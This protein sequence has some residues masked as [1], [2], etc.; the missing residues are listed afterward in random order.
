[1]KIIDRTDSVRYIRWYDSTSR[2]NKYCLLCKNLF[3]V[4]K[5]FKTSSEMITGANKIRTRG[6]IGYPIGPILLS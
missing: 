4:T 3:E 2:F 1:M 6:V 5:R